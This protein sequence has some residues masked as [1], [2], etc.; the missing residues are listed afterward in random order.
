MLKQ[1]WPTE[2]VFFLGAWL[3]LVIVGRSQFFADPGSLWHIVVGQRILESGELIH[4]DPFSFTFAGKPWIAQWWLA[5]CLLASLHRAGGLDAILLAMATLLA[6]FYTWL[7]HRFLRAGLHPLLAVLLT[8]LAAAASSYHFHARPH[9]F[10][11]VLLGWTFARLCDF[12]ASRV[13]LRSLFWLVP[14]FVFWTN[15][16]GGMVGGVA[17]LAL[18]VA[19]WGCAKLLGQDTPLVRYSQL[20]PL[21]GLVVACGLTAF[22]NPYGIELPLAWFALMMS[23]VLPRIMVEHAPLLQAGLSAW[24]VLLLGFVYL[25]ALVGVWPARP[26][27]TWLVPL[28]WFVLAW[29]RIRHG[30]L[31]AATAALALADMLPHVR[32]VAWLARQGSV[33]CRLRP[34]AGA[35]GGLDWRALPIP[36]LI[37]LSTGVLLPVMGRGWARPDQRSCPLELLPEL[38]AC[39]AGRSQG[40]PVFNEMLFGGFL[41]YYSPDLRVFIDDRCELYGDRWLEEFAD[42]QSQHPDK[43]ETWAREYG[44]E[45]AF[46]LPHSGFGRYLGDASGWA[47]VKRTEHAVLFRR[48]VGVTRAD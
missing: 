35:G 11:I 3:L 44:F 26:R 45:Y 23:P 34:V 24:L 25:A 17:T 8:T 36:L 41:I 32:W 39:A 43:I 38:R 18:T 22:I 19:G 5:E 10:T 42:A 27:V 21:G 13:P 28:V 2:T 6:G 14:V 1:F 9:V 46:V 48:T 29:T 33:A 4:A 31:F 47:E 37:V 16:H 7:V 30:P 12:E 40:T 15:V 20:I